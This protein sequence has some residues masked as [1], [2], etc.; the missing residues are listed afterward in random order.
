MSQGVTA[1]P[2]TGRRGTFHECRRSSQTARTT[3]SFL[4]IDPRIALGGE[5]SRRREIDDAS[6]RREVH[7]AGT[8]AR[9]RA[10][11]KALRALAPQHDAGS[12][13]QVVEECVLAS[14]ME[15]APT[16]LQPDLQRL[17]QQVNE[18]RADQSSR[19]ERMPG[20]AG[21]RGRDY[22]ASA[23]DVDSCASW[24]SSR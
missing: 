1:M 15:T 17:V 24:T 4:P 3:G 16:K 23:T 19:R 10:I 22:P 12:I 11:S 7:D 20:D 13:W 21:G 2:I 9:E 8:G 6:R 14:Q 5:E 18:S